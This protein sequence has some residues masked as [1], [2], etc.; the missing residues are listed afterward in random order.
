MD[1][2]GLAVP[3]DVVGRVGL[4]PRLAGETEGEDVGIGSPSPVGAE[5]GGSVSPPSWLQSPHDGSG[6]ATIGCPTVMVPISHMPDRTISFGPDSLA[7][8]PT[9]PIISRIG[10]PTVAHIGLG[11]SGN[12]GGEG[13]DGGQRRSSGAPIDGGV[14]S[15]R[16]TAAAGH[17]APVPSTRSGL[18]DP[19]P[20]GGE[21]EVLGR[22][23]HPP[24]LGVAQVGDRGVDR[25]TVA[26]RR[27]A[28]F[29]AAVV[30]EGGSSTSAAGVCSG[31]GTGTRHAGR[32][33]A[34]TST[35]DVNDDFYG[36]QTGFMMGP[37]RD[38]I[39]TM[40]LP[41][42]QE[43]AREML[44]NPSVHS[45]STFR[46]SAS[47]CGASSSAS[48]ANARVNAPPRGPAAPALRTTTRTQ[49]RANRIAAPP[50]GVS[51]RNSGPLG[52]T[53]SRRPSVVVEGGGDSAAAPTPGL[54]LPQGDAHASLSAAIAGLSASVLSPD[55]ADGSH[56]TPALPAARSRTARARGGIQCA[57]CAGLIYST[58][59]AG[60]A[61]YATHLMARH[62]GIRVSISHVAKLDGVI[63]LCDCGRC[64][65]ASDVECTCGLQART[66]RG[67]RVGDT[68]TGRAPRRNVSSSRAQ[69]A[70]LRGGLVEARS[71]DS[72]LPPV[73]T[74]LERVSEED[75]RLIADEL[76]AWGGSETLVHI[77]VRSRPLLASVFADLLTA[78]VDGN[79]RAGLLLR[80][81]PKLT[82]HRATFRVLGHAA[83]VAE[84]RRR[85]ALLLEGKIA[86]LATLVR[87]QRAGQSRMS[88]KRARDSQNRSALPAVA[89]LARNGAC[90]KAVRRLT[91]CIASY[92]DDDARRWARTLIPNPPDGTRTLGA[93]PISHPERS[94]LKD[95][96]TCADSFDPRPNDPPPQTAGSSSANAIPIDSSGS[97]DD[98]DDD[99]AADASD[100]EAP[101][102][103]P[104]TSRPAARKPPATAFG[105]G[106][107]FGALS[108][109][110]PSGLRPEHLR[111]FGMSR[112]VAARH[113][114]EDAMRRFVAAA[115]RGDLPP[116]SCWWITDSSLTFARKPN[117][118][119]V[120]CPSSSAR[121]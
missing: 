104:R 48:S 3:R 113:K 8:A 71:A 57:F 74:C 1:V 92:G 119:G 61:S 10:L 46:L 56:P 34:E 20:V 49:S 5:G 30:E 70:A 7:P 21:V 38:L 13:T 107:R 84:L 73:S 51:S 87:E 112:H 83:A 98:E 18:D 15:M 4:G 43:I 118:A 17:T 67:L 58:T 33:A 22:G 31:T 77:P 111:A 65:P 103:H 11:A 28:G 82:L 24:H 66:R 64:C 80:C 68:I 54:S 110:G 105:S 116:D 59:D 55:A 120:R 97:G 101:Q 85:T 42:T 72:S 117:S 99:D 44:S 115:V 9:I 81:L 78:M 96:R 19:I 12:D 89:N 75:L 40:S 86:E 39:Q 109:P 27:G 29:P 32:D 6:A 95:L 114:Y 23:T 79:V 91:S 60:K 88:I 53:A 108:A 100:D 35:V 69:R 94:D 121:W 90:S 63:N 45:P 26:D 16:T 37:G 25:M 62:S 76:D 36:D 41:S 50:A 102:R 106:V 14:G 47:R 52:S 2:C 93:R